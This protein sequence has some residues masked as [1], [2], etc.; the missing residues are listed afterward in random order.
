LGARDP[1]LLSDRERL[2]N[3]LPVILLFL[4]FLVL[5]SHVKVNIP[6]FQP[7]AWDKTFTAWD[8][9]LFFNHLPFELL[10]P[11][12]VNPF[13]LFL[14]N[15]AYNF[16]YVLMLGTMLACAFMRKRSEQR[17]RYLVAFFLVWL[18]EGSFLAVA[19]SSAGPC[20][21][22][23]LGIHPNP[24]QPLMKS[25]RDADSVLPIFALPTQDMLWS[26]Y[27]GEGKPAGISAMPSL[28][29]ALAILMALAARPFGRL[30]SLAFT[31]YAVWIFLGSI[32][33]AWHYAVDGLIALLVTVPIWALCGYLARWWHEAPSARKGGTFNAQQ[34]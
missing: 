5:F 23:A 15:V 25:L 9:A 18:L 28:H 32:I 22:E 1:F 17:T 3:G 4:P 7:F 14:T 21:Y 29:N 12:M 27:I 13:V 30:I 10:S 16:W 19:F 34:N 2:S 33:L 6:V 26:G 24:Y 8:R 20:F 11:I 31:A